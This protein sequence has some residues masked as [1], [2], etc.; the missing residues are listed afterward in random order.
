MLLAEARSVLKV[1]RTELVEGLELV[2]VSE[3]GGK[4]EERNRRTIKLVDEETG[5]VF[6]TNG[7]KLTI[8]FFETDAYS[9]FYIPAAR[10][11]CWLR[12]QPV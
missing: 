7:A 5:Y 3:R 9:Y 1:K 2:V 4:W 6:F 12:G 10:W 11:E 8:S